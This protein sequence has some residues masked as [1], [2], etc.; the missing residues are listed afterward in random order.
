M[1]INEDFP[2]YVKYH[3]LIKELKK[4]KDIKGL[5]RYIADHILPVLVKKTDQTVNS[6]A[7]LLDIRYGRSRTDKVEDGI[8]D[9]FKSREDNHEDDDELG[10]M[11]TGCL[12]FDLAF[13]CQIIIAVDLRQ[14]MK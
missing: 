9:L 3:D 6:V 13:R 5:Q 12:S 8:E 4:N 14:N 11:S 7:G 10:D 1:E 2:E